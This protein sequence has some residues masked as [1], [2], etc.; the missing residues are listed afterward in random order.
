[1]MI[2]CI[3]LNSIVTSPLYVLCSCRTLDIQ[4]KSNDD[5]LTLFTNLQRQIMTLKN[6]SQMAAAG[7]SVS[8]PL[9]ATAARPAS[10]VR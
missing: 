5:F 3:F 2:Y 10:A 8:S 4:C 7:S 1:M 6:A 9:S